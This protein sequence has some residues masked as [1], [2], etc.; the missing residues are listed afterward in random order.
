[1][2]T[3]SSIVIDSEIP[4]GISVR[5]GADADAARRAAAATMQLRLR[6]TAHIRTLLRVHSAAL[7]A[8]HR[9][10]AEAQAERQDLIQQALRHRAREEWVERRW[11]ALALVRVATRSERARGARELAAVDA[12]RRR[13]AEAAAGLAARLEALC[14]RVDALADGD[15]IHAP[16]A[17]VS[18]GPENE[19]GSARY[20][21][22][23]RYLGL[24][25]RLDADGRLDSIEPQFSALSDACAAL[26]ARSE[27][28]FAEDGPGR[29]HPAGEALSP[30]QA[31]QQWAALY[32]QYVDYL[33]PLAWAPA[34]DVLTF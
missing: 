22:V 31:C 11:A 29:D 25:R 5:P 6:G 28:A 12:Q 14:A 2:E 15:P 3:R 10:H 9:A 30:A 4:A 19:P 33:R 26:V 17:P 1:M 23:G 21:D 16:L 18:L 20:V 32:Q 8:H 7:V 27:P 34:G 13:T 24:V